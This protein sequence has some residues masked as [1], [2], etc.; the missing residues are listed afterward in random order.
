MSLSAIIGWL[1]VLDPRIWQAIIG[2]SFLATGW[3]VNGAQNR[4]RDRKLREEKVRDYQHALIAEIRAYVNVL[5]RDDLDAFESEM[6]RRIEADPAFFPFIPS[7][8][9]DTVFKALV[10]NIQ[11][12]PRTSIDPVTVYYSYIDAIHAMISDLRALGRADV[13]DERL[14]LMYG[15]Y[16]ALKRGALEW[17]EEAR[18]MMETYLEGGPAAVETLL[19]ERESAERR[20]EAAIP[21]PSGTVNSPGAD[22][23]GR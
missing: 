1:A 5:R 12:L 3:L 13:S 19:S 8:K 16:I 18:L 9:N 23:S 14:I 21:A 15:D 22:P 10:E 6:V 11:V 2:G 7:E 20:A 17:G 4:A